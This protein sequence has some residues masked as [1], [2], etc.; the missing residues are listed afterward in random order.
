ME[1]ITRERFEELVGEALDEL[2]AWVVE[3][4]DNVS[5]Q[6]EDLPPGGQP[7]LLGLYHGV[8]LSERGR[9]YTNVLPDTITLYRATIMGVAGRDE[10]RLRAVVTHT[11]AHEIAHHF[12]ISDARLLEIDAY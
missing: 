7:G 8:P 9:G 6:V 1:P 4:M 3:A 12:G 10:R 5:V 11:V 2:P